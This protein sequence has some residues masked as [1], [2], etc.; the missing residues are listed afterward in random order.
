MK[1]DTGRGVDKFGT[2]LSVN[3]IQNFIARVLVLFDEDSSSCI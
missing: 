1:G 2:E 3:V